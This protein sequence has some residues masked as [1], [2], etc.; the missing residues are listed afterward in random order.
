[1]ANVLP[2]NRVHIQLQNKIVKPDEIKQIGK[3]SKKDAF[4]KVTELRVQEG[5]IYIGHAQEN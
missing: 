5:H 2:D 4:D 3:F 1:M